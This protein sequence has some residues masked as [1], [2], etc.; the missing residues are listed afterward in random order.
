MNH[1][2]Q[3]ERE[4]TIKINQNKLTKKDKRFMGVLTLDI[5]PTTPLCIKKSYILKKTLKKQA[6]QIKKGLLT[7]FTGRKLPQ[8]R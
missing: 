2:N 5:L 3:P 8:Q 4:N 7:V 1:K 6:N